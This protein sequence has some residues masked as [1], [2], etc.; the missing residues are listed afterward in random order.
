MKI[1]TELQA[2]LDKLDD[3]DDFEFELAANFSDDSEDSDSGYEW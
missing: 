1:D 3:N 2:E